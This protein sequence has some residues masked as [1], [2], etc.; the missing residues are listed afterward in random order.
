MSNLAPCPECQ[1]KFGLGPLCIV[2]G[3]LARFRLYLQSIRCP[4]AIGVRIAGR[5]GEL[6]RAVL[7]DAE[8]YWASP[9][10]PAAGVSEPLPPGVAPKSQAAPKHRETAGGSEGRDRGSGAED[11]DKEPVDIKEERVASPEKVDK[12]VA[13]GVGE[14]ASEE[15]HRSDRK[16]RSR[17]RQ[18]RKHKR[19]QSVSEEKER[20]AP[21]PRKKEKKH[22][23][24][25][26]EPRE[27][28]VSPEDREVREAWR[29]GST[30]GVPSSAH[31]PT[32]R[33]RS[34]SRS[35]RADRRWKGA[36]PA[37]NREASAPPAQEAKRKKQNKGQKKR[38]RNAAFYQATR[39]W[40]RCPRR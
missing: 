32:R 38:E 9:S 2:C 12:V 37:G 19:E 13:A 16:S 30:E 34:P 28:S 29:R 20:E 31:P 35:P 26:E 36:I 25:S 24:R 22:R 15:P 21:L 10:E 18:R 23:S 27:D 14:A 4:S 11:R 6:Q 5:I 3:G 7:D 40:Y 33:P 39:E 8:F 17:H 1:G